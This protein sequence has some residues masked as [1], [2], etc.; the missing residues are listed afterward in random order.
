MNTAQAKLFAWSSAGVLG[1]ALSFY[2]VNFAR[3]QDE[4]R[5][6]VT[7]QQMKKVL[8]GVKESAGTEETGP[9]AYDEIKR[10]W[11]NLNWS[12]REKDKVTVAPEQAPAQEPSKME[13]AKL[14]KVL[15]VS[16]VPSKPEESSCY[17]KYSQEARVSS[18]AVKSGVAMKRIGDKLDEPH[19]TVRIHQITADGVEFAFA[20]A[21]RAHETLTVQEYDLMPHIVRVG[22]GQDPQMP[23]EREFPRAQT[24]GQHPQRTIRIGPNQIKVGT[25]DAQYI[26]ENYDRIFANELRIEPHRDPR[27]GK[28]DGIELVDVKPDS[29]AAAHGAKS[30]DVIKAING[31]PVK[32]QQ[33]AIQFVKTNANLYDKWEIL[34]EN[35]GQ[36]RTV[37]IYPPPPK[38]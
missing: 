31:H 23:E 19:G 3:N 16:W 38:D 34:I 20:D 33:E 2:M 29:I 25:E 11:I 24:Y 14:L 35:M 22:D 9:I 27:T 6:T 17:V 4:T 15:A 8:E 32:S 37:T 21:A 1:A 36:E 7:L 13:V 26:S 10:T 28:R 30:G 5:Q 12:G 18:P